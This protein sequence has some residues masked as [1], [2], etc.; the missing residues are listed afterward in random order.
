MASPLTSHPVTIK[1]YLKFKAPAGCRDE[2]VYGTIIVSPEPKLLHFHIADKLHELLKKAAGKRYRVAQRVNLR[3]PKLNSMPSPDVFVVAREEYDSALHA[4]TY[5]DGTRV[6]LAVEVLSPGNR[7][8]AVQSKINL[9]CKHGIEVW[10]VNPKTQE[11]RIFR[12][13]ETILLNLS[14]NQTLTLPAK[15]GGKAIPLSRVFDLS[16]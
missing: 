11:I 9:Y 3:F 16:T 15:L 2:L 5:P 6:I 4:S 13:H 7:K 1:E 10:V 8:K 14:A 12:D